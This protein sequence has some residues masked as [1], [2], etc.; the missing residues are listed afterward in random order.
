M[1]SAQKQPELHRI[2]EMLLKNFASDSRRKKIYR[3]DLRVPNSAPEEIEIS[4][5]TT[6]A[7][8]YPDSYEDYL[9]RIESDTKLIFHRLIK[10]L[11]KDITIQL[12]IQE[13]EKITLAKFYNAYKFRSKNIQES[14]F[15][16]PEE[17]NMTEEEIRTARLTAI[18]NPDLIEN[19]KSK[20]FTVITT[21]PPESNFILC[22][23]VLA[24]PDQ[25]EK[26]SLYPVSSKIYI[27][28]TN[29]DNSNFFKNILIR[30][31]ENKNITSFLNADMFGRARVAVYGY[32][33]TAEDLNNAE[34]EW[35]KYQ[36]TSVS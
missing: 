23:S 17:K 27:L 2:P 21:N 4:E 16:M 18:N 24:I 30:H 7:N 33:K 20:E 35:L 36:Q 19:I 34:K 3:K 15:D 11:R 12:T 13:D 29:P 28:L 8:A 25:E 6:E 1:T 14:N 5:A 22:D 10:A 32:G 31:S 9:Q 26:Y